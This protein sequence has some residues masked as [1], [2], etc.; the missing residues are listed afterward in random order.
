MR[1]QLLY[2]IHGL[3]NCDLLQKITKYLYAIGRDMRPI[4]IVERNFPNNI[5]QNELPVIIIN[6]CMLVGLE[7]IVNYYEQECNIDN[8]I[9]KSIE[10]M[11]L[12]PR[13]QISDKASH[14]NIRFI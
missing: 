3:P 6:D 14:K 1:P 7:S 2:K 4:S 8:L 5:N 13:Y 12:N 9:N 10:F 11:K